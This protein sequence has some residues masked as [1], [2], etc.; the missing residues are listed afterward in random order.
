MNKTLLILRRCGLN[1]QTV[2]LSFYQCYSSKVFVPDAPFR[3]TPSS[4]STG[5][6]TP[7]S[8]TKPAYLWS[9]SEV[10][11]WL[12][13]HCPRHYP[14]LLELFSRHDITGRVLLRLTEA[15][16]ARMGIGGLAPRQE[17]L[18]QLLLLRLREDALH[19]SLLAQGAECVLVL[20]FGCWDECERNKRRVLVVGTSAERSSRI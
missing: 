14:S 13:R 4:W 9:V 7:T 10:C 11:R 20:S 6:V 3:Q 16:L 2:E 8:P 18:A 5:A 12:K 19:L 15:T 17:L 1:L